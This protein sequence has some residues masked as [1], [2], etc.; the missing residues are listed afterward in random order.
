MRFSRDRVGYKAPEEIIVLDEM[1][2][3]AVGKVDRVALVQM[4]DAA[5]NR[6]LA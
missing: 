3:N 5:V 6:H 4:A 1:P 2:I